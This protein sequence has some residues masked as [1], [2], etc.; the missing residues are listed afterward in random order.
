MIISKSLYGYIQAIEV[1]S[2]PFGNKGN[3]IEYVRTDSD[4]VYF[5]DLLNEQITRAVEERYIK[6]GDT[7]SIQWNTESSSSLPNVV[8]NVLTTIESN[9]ESQDAR[10]LQKYEWLKNYADLCTNGY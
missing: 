2:Y 1:N 4:G 9:M 7:F 10:I 5:L 3:L 6:T 8:R